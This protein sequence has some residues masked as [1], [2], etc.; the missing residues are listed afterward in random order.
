M[1]L[2]LVGVYM[3]VYVLLWAV[4][5]ERVAPLVPMAAVGWKTARAYPR[6]TPTSDDLKRCTKC[7]E[8]KPRAGVQPPRSR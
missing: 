8:E 4:R 6:P 7:S 5:D 1:T 2:L 3:G